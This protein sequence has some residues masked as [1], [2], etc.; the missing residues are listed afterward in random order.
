MGQNNKIV[1][2]DKFKTKKVMTD[3]MTSEDPAARERVHPKN[4]RSAIDKNSPHL[5]ASRELSNWSQNKSFLQN[6]K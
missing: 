1:C 5:P 3:R 4:L 2:P 6:N